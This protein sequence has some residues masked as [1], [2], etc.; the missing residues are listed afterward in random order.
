METIKR[1]IMDPTDID[2]PAYCL[3]KIQI[4]NVLN[5]TIDKMDIRDCDEGAVTIKISLKTEETALPYKENTV[6]KLSVDWKVTGQITEKTQT[7]GDL[8]DADKYYMAVDDSGK[9]ILKRIEEAQHTMD[10]YI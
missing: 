3:L 9:M 7:D 2:D 8:Y 4:H 6:K 5:E 1:K 10:E